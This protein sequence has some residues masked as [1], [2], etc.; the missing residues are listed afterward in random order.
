ML[1]GSI[2]LW[3]HPVDDPVVVFLAGPEHRVEPEAR[4]V[5]GVG[6]DLGLEAKSAV[7]AI[8]TVKKGCIIA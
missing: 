2:L 6:I 7:L 4:V 8:P 3:Q 5:D 1:C